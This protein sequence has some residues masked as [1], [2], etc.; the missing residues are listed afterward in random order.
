MTVVMEDSMQRFLR[1]A[2]IGAALLAGTAAAHAQYIVE[3]PAYVAPPAVAIAPAPAYVAPAPAYAAPAP[4]YIVPGPSYVAPAPR[5][6]VAQPPMTEEIVTQPAPQTIVATERQSIVQ[7]QANVRETVVERS[8]PARSIHRRARTTRV[9]LTSRQRRDVLRTIRYERTATP[10]ARE[11]VVTTTAAPVV[12][13]GVGSVLPATVPTYAMPREV[14][15][16]A[17]ALQ[18]YAYAPV[19]N[20]MLVVEPA[21]NTVVEELR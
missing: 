19:G 11:R 13:Y 18:G 7:P 20:R 3:Q 4:A 21:S 1:T 16:E 12:S 6:V 2:S 5:V 9:H 14:V 17:P 15:Y 8:A 10:I